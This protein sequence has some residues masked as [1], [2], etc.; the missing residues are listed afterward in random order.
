MRQAN[1]RPMLAVTQFEDRATPAVLVGYSAGTLTL[2]ARSG[3]VITVSNDPVDIPGQ[4]TIT[5][6]T[7]TVF[8][9]NGRSVH[10]LVINGGQAANYNLGFGDNV[11]LNNLTVG[12]GTGGTGVILGATTRIA[13]AFTFNGSTAGGNDSLQFDPGSRIGGGARINLR[14]GNNGLFSTAGPSA[15]TSSSPPAAGPIPS[16]WRPPAT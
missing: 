6:G 4:L 16:N 5:D 15:G 1:R 12:G 13:R 2:S 14:G 8:T 10:N 3:D 7:R 11:V 9:S